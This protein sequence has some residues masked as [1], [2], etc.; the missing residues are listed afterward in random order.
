MLPNP[1]YSI[2]TSNGRG[3]LK[4]SFDLLVGLEVLQ[5][6]WE[7]ALELSSVVHEEL[8]GPW[9]ICCLGRLILEIVLRKK[10]NNPELLIN[11]VMLFSEESSMGVKIWDYQLKK[12]TSGGPPFNLYFYCQFSDSQFLSCCECE[13][14]WYR[15]S[16]QTRLNWNRFQMEFSTRMD[17]PWPGPRN[18]HPFPAW[19]AK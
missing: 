13:M 17:E 12:S 2:T 5:H 19:P 8:T 6:G 18:V 7:F 10:I 3:V 15:L 16:I 4:W 14:R 9:A 11:T 1:A